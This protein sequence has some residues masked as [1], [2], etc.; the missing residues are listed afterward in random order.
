MVNATF[1]LLDFKNMLF[2][3]SIKVLF[4]SVYLSFNN[5]MFLI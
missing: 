1:S 5:D 2:F 4:L 3:L